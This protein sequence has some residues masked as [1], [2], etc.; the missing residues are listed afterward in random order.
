MEREHPIFDAKD[1]PKHCPRCH[2]LTFVD[3]LGSMVEARSI[4]DP[5][6]MSRYTCKVCGE[7]WIIRWPDDALFFAGTEET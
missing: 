4:G 3:G 5:P 2:V 7:V 1:A 6:R